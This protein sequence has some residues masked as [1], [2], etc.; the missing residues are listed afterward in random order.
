VGNFEFNEQGYLVDKSTGDYVMANNGSGTWS[1]V[2]LDGSM[3]GAGDVELHPSSG[4]ADVKID[5]TVIPTTHPKGTFADIT[6]VSINSDGTISASIDNETGTL[7]IGTGADAKP[8]T[9]GLATFLN[10]S[11]LTQVGN[12]FY[13][14]NASSGTANVAQP[15]VGN[16]TTI[17]TGAL[18]SSNVDLAT[19]MTNM[20]VTQRGYQADARVIT[21]SDSLLEELVNLKRS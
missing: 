10:S 5:D 12:N 9:I 17:V 8:I 3:T 7:Q 4:A 1:T 16:D 15:G 6:N 19:E 13:T 2:C 11:G 21:V 18:E 14:A 20:I